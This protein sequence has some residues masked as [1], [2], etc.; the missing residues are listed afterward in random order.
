MSS[1]AYWVTNTFTDHSS[2]IIQTPEGSKKIDLFGKTIDDHILALANV[3]SSYGL[4]TIKTDKDHVIFNHAL[5]SCLRQEY[6][7]NENEM[8][9]L[10][11]I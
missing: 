4:V 7:Y 11:E 1:V 5:N 6:G 8:V 2:V 10:E 9:K 3:V